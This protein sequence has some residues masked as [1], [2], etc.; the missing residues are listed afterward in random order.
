MITQDEY[1]AG[2]MEEALEPYA[3]SAEY[4][5]Q[6]SSIN[7][8]MRNFRNTLTSKDQIEQF[9]KLMDRINMA[10]GDFTCKAYEAGFKEAFYY[11]EQVLDR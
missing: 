3:T 8:E 5:E 7:A 9:N 2:S 4:R 1:I 10:H 6:T 11:Q